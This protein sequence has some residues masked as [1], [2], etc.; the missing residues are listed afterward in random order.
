MQRACVRFDVVSGPPLFVLIILLRCCLQYCF[1]VPDMLLVV[2][3]WTVDVWRLMTTLTFALVV[4]M[5]PRCRS[6]S[7]RIPN[8]AVQNPSA[9]ECSVDT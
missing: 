9:G 6:G 2:Y 3:L 7:V 1:G 4:A 5:Q 8:S